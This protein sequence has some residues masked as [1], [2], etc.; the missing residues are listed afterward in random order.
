MQ[1]TLSSVRT[2]I[3]S[4]RQV[5]YELMN[6]TSIRRKRPGESKQS[7][8]ARAQAKQARIRK[9]VEEERCKERERLSRIINAA[10]LPYIKKSEKK[11]PSMPRSHN[12]R[13]KVLITKSNQRNYYKNKSSLVGRN[14]QYYRLCVF[15]SRTR[16]VKGKGRKNRQCSV[17]RALCE[18]NYNNEN[19][20]GKTGFD[21][22]MMYLAAQ[23]LTDENKTM[24]RRR[25]RK[26]KKRR[27]RRKKS[28]ARQRAKL[29]DK[30][31]HVQRGDVARVA[32][33]QACIENEL[34]KIWY[35]KHRVRQGTIFLC[36]YPSLRF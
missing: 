1:R 4:K 25:R 30:K 14:L 28:D 13:R 18:K 35:H 20:P 23:G 5:R 9:E 27:K 24:K 10:R 6:P 36:L 16:R 3:E 7:K 2:N 34:Y 19:T 32:R 12:Y 26:K 11:K 29:E 33:R 17:A 21:N 15:A 22:A 8:R 31:G